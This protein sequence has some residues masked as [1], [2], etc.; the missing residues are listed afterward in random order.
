MCH[1]K[2]HREEGL[3]L[4]SAPSLSGQ[5]SDYR[6]SRVLFLGIPPIEEVSGCGVQWAELLQPC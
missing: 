4:M 5:V 1:V 3:G 6:L 2:K